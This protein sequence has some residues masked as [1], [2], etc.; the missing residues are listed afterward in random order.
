MKISITI[1]KATHENLTYEVTQ[2]NKWLS[3][4]I[5]SGFQGLFE[6][7]RELATVQATARQVIHLTEE[8]ESV[9]LDT[10]HAI[11]DF[12]KKYSENFSRF[13]DITVLGKGGEAVVFNVVPYK[14]ME[15]IAKVPLDNGDNNEVFAGLL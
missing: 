6:N 15:V 5:K 9:V 1:K 12:L 4:K 7:K 11:K 2:H 3:T 8:K 10:D 13:E 14:P